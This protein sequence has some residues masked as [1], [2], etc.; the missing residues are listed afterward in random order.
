MMKFVQGF[1]QDRE[2]IFIGYYTKAYSET[3]NAE[4]TVSVGTFKLQV[5]LYLN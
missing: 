4:R 1:D 2:F 3:Q 5:P